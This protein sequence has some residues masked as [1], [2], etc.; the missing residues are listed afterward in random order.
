VPADEPAVVPLV[1][2]RPKTRRD[3]EPVTLLEL[4]ALV[5][6]AVLSGRAARVRFQPRLREIARSRL[7]ITRGIDLDADP[8]SAR[9]VVGDQAWVVLG[10]PQGP[11]PEPDAPGVALADI[12]AAATAL[13]A[14]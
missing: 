8:A 4:E 10:P 9:A 12:A 11:V 1:V 2:R 3:H 14:L 5:D 13:E 7:A 6:A